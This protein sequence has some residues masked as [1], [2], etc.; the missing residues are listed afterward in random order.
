MGV[1]NRFPRTRCILKQDIQ[2]T[3]GSGFE[4]TE[5]ASLSIIEHSVVVETSSSFPPR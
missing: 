1:G 3:V 5:R 4:I 2:L